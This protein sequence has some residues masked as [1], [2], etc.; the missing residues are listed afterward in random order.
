MC[1]RLFPSWAIMNKLHVLKM[2]CNLKDDYDVVEM[3][4][5]EKYIVISE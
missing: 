4:V 2:T 5:M 1:H 3:K